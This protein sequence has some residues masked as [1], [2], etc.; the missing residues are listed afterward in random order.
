MQ[1]GRVVA[2]LLAKGNIDIKVRCIIN[3]D[4]MA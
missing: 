4:R 3:P 2:A 1:K